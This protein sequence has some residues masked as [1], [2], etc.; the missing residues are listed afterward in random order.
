V[1]SDAFDPDSAPPLP[2]GLGGGAAVTVLWRPGCPFCALLLRRLERTGLVFDRIDI[3][4]EPDAAAW[5]RTVADGNETVPTVRIAGADAD[6]AVALVN[7]SATA[8]LEQVARLA[9]AH[10]PAVRPA[11]SESSPSR[12]F[13]RPL[14]R[15]G[16]RFSALLKERFRGRR[17]RGRGRAAPR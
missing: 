13:A 9:P 10:L 15:L 12:P 7:P 3:W 8:V 1:T 5:V 17:G 16:E 11:S 4:E 2:E 14:A 6:A